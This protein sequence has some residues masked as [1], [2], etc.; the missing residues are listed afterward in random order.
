ML[1]TSPLRPFLLPQ[2]A[3]RPAAGAVRSRCPNAR[4][5]RTAVQVTTGRQQP[6]RDT[7]HRCY[8]H[9]VGQAT[10]LVAVVLVQVVEQRCELLEGAQPV[11]SGRK[12][13]G[14][15][16]GEKGEGVCRCVS[17]LEWQK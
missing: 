17:I 1:P 13:G 16:E 4:R 11:D 15:G 6:K 8:S 7:S 14:R 9:C 12:E 2:Q 10:C 5:W 3:G